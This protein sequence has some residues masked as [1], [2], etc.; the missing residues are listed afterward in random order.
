MNQIKQTGADRLLD[1]EQKYEEVLSSDPTSN[2]FCILAE[3]QYKLGNLTITKIILQRDFF[4][5]KST[6]K[7]GS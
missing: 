2:A 4:L 5:E 1:L 6:M 7:D 3:V